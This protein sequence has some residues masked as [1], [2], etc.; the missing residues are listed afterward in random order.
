[1][2]NLLSVIDFK[3]VGQKFSNNRF[4]KGFEVG[5]FSKEFLRKLFAMHKKGIKDLLGRDVWKKVE[6][7]CLNFHKAKFI[8][9]VGRVA[10]DGCWCS[11]KVVMDHWVKKVLHGGRSWS[12]RT[13]RTMVLVCRSFWRAFLKSSAKEN[14]WSGTHVTSGSLRSDLVKK[15]EVF[16]CGIKNQADMKEVGCLLD[17]SMCQVHSANSSPALKEAHWRNCHVG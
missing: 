4:S 6:G 13:K 1:M 8:L 16:I 5:S 10:D 12:N 17:I 11:R 15:E 7:G 2:Q 14:A 9:S 3:E